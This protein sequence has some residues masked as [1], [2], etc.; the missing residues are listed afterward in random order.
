MNQLTKM[1]V[2]AVLVTQ[3]ML[4][5]DQASNSVPGLAGSATPES[6]APESDGVAV[7]SALKITHIDQVS[8]L[9]AAFMRQLAAQTKDPLFSVSVVDGDLCSFMAENAEEAFGLQNWRVECRDYFPSLC[10]KRFD[11]KKLR[12]ELRLAAD[13]A[14]KPC[15]LDQLQSAYARV[16]QRLKSD[17]VFA[18]RQACSVNLLFGPAPECLRFVKNSTLIEEAKAIRILVSKLGMGKD[19][20]CFSYPLEAKMDYTYGYCDRIFVWVRE[21]AFEAFQKAFGLDITWS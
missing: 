21:D 6:I 2:I 14:F 5:M 13:N 17:W 10:V 4:A 16:M 20:Q 15:S 8:G 7:T 19:V 1:F 12:C 3:T 9:C 18:G 11:I